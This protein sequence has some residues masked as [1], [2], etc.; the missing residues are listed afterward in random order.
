[1]RIEIETK[2]DKYNIYYCYK[3]CEFDTKIDWKD[4]KNVII[5]S[6]LININGKRIKE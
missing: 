4:N 1:M 2:K 6:R 5:G 3:E